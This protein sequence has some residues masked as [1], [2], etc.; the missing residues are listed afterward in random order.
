MNDEPT[1]KRYAADCRFLQRTFDSSRID[2]FVTRCRHIVRDGEDCVGPFLDE[3]ETRC[4]LWE[5]L[6][7]GEPVEPWGKIP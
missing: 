7:I 5:P 1:P 6:P 3:T 4:Q 2:S